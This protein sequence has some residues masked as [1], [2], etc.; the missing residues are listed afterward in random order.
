VERLSLTHSGPIDG[1]DD[2]L[3]T[4]FFVGSARVLVDGLSESLQFCWCVMDR[5]DAEDYQTCA[6]L[7]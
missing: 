1:H 5:D 2:N 4:A 6:T 7:R 3:V